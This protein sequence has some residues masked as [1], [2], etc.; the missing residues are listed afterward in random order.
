MLIKHLF[1]FF[2]GKKLSI[3]TRKRTTNTIGTLNVLDAQLR[4]VHSKSQTNPDIVLS[5]RRLKVR[6]I[7][8]V[9]VFHIAVWFSF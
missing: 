2:F 8:V 7:I 6:E 9:T 4:S 1:I 5:D 3:K